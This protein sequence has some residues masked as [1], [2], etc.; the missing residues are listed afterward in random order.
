VKKYEGEE[1]RISREPFEGHSERRFAEK[2]S[3]FDWI[4]GMRLGVSVL[5]LLI[6]W[7]V[8]GMVWFFSLQNE[9]SQLQTWKDIYKEQTNERLTKAEKVLKDLND[10]IH[11]GN[12]TLAE[13]KVRLEI[14][15]EALK[16]E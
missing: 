10:E 6:F 8:T 9:V 12:I 4:G 11:A 3:A 15:V 1:R 16:N 7:M 13:M 14:I 5:T 2:V